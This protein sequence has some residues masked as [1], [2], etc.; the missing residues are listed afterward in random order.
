MGMVHAEIEILNM[1]DIINAKNN[2][3]DQDEI[4]RMNI[5]VLVDTGSYF[6]CINENIQAYLNLPFLEKRRMRT[7][8]D[9]IVEYDVVGPVEVRFAN[10]KAHCS[11]FLLTGDSEPMLGAVPMKQLDVIVHPLRQE[12]HVNNEIYLLPTL[13]LE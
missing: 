12:L 1:E 3:I 13:K 4:R 7:A 8:D 6:F 2:L 11:A 9:R 5:R 10:K